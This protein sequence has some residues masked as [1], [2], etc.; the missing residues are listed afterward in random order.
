MVPPPLGPRKCGARFVLGVHRPNTK[1]D[2]HNPHRAAGKAA[3]AYAFRT[4][5]LPRDGTMARKQPQATIG[6]QHCYGPNA[7]QVYAFVPKRYTA[8]YEQYKGWPAQYPTT[9]GSMHGSRHST[10]ERCHDG[11]CDIPPLSV[12]RRS[13]AECSAFHIPRTF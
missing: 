8:S 4:K 2:R 12:V 1:A 7:W 11:Q 10:V 5:A 6:L 9:D 13:L 3:R